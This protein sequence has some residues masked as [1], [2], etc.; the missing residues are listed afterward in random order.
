MNNSLHMAKVTGT[1]TL[2]STPWENAK[3]NAAKFLQN[4]QCNENTVLQ[5]T[6]TNISGHV[7]DVRLQ[8]QVCGDSDGGVIAPH[9]WKVRNTF[10]T[11]L[12]T[13]PWSNYGGPKGLGP[14]KDQVA[15]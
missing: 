15:P 1:F 5:Y 13:L 7:A 12:H 4:R 10:C 3:L 8:G 6:F 2:Q 14:L 9:T 11:M